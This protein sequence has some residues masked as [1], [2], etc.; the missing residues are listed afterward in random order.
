[1]RRFATKYQRY[2]VWVLQDGLC[3]QCQEPLSDTFDVDHIQPFS[4]GGSTELWNLQALCLACHSLKH[5]G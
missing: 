4:E 3:A 5:F 2:Q 1:M